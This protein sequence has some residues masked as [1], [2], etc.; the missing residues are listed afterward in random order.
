MMSRGAAADGLAG[1]FAV[2]FDSEV[3]QTF[4]SRYL[5]APQSSLRRLD[6]VAPTF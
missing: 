6:D 4:V 1:Q 3:P 5:S 2:S